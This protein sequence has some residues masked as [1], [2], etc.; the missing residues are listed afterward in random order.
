MNF[1]PDKKYRGSIKD[2]CNSGRYYVKKNKFGH[3][4]IFVFRL[5]FQPCNL[6]HSIY[7][8]SKF[9]NRDKIK[10]K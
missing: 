6:A 7:Y 8:D 3:Q 1:V 10:R 4:L 5:V 2:Q 9:S